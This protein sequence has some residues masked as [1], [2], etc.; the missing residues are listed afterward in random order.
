MTLPA[1]LRLVGK[2]VGDVRGS[3]RPRDAKDTERK[4]RIVVLAYDHTVVA[5]ATDKTAPLGKPGTPSDKRSHGLFV[6]TKPLDRATPTLHK[7]A[8]EGDEFST[9]VLQCF[10][11]P[12]AG[13]G[14]NG[15]LEEGHWKIVLQ[16]A[17]IAWIKTVMKNVRVPANSALPEME[18]VA[19][20]YD[21]IGFGWAALTGNGAETFTK[22]SSA[23]TG[24]FR[25]S[26]GH[27][28]AKRIVDKACEQ[29][30]GEIGKQVAA[31]LKDEGKK[32]FLDALKEK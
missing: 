1:I 11:V 2:K 28:I 31:F 25:K 7:A 27:M 8:C 9:F 5:E 14:P 4:G 20:T 13:G 6:V 32:M 18:E 29:V 30:G 3:A 15:V 21:T 16:G 22:E 23:L 17:R 10:R 26:D 12:P 24:D 19:F